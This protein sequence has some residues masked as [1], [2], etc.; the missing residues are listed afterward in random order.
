[1]TLVLLDDGYGG[2]DGVQV[3]PRVP[4]GQANLEHP[5]RD[6]V[7]AHPSILPAAELEPG[8]GRIAAVATELSLPGAGFADVLLVSE[9]GRLILV[10]CKLWRNPQARREVVVQILDYARELAH[11]D[12]EDLQRA[13]S[14]RVGRSGNV[15]YELAREAGSTMTEAAFVDR[16]GRDLRAGRFLL[17]I[18]GDGITE[19]TQR[20]TEYLNVP[21]LAFGFGLIEMAEYR[22]TDPATGAARRIMQPRV[23]ARTATIERHVIRSD[24]PGVVIDAVEQDAAPIRRRSVGGSSNG[25]STGAATGA[26]GEAHVAWRAF[27]AA[28][29]AGMQ[30]DDPG[31]LAPRIGGLNWMRVPLPGPAPLV[32][33]RSTSTQR[34]GAFLKYTG[35]EAF[36]AFEALEADREAIAAEFTDDGLEAPEWVSE[37]DVHTVTVRAP[38]PL[39][40]DGAREDEQRA[41]LARA[42]NRF[43]NSFRPRLLRMA[44]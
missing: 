6:I 24:V 5:L 42:A 36:A 12:Y 31:Q 22:Y 7:F 17:L 16:V 20:L 35:A 19:G 32:L 40:W 38:S 3:V 43:V 10:E 34:V 39:P 9:H 23:I 21:G 4:E 29:T 15:L 28:F 30:F 25:G 18:V 14:D 1:M 44:A 13:I 26:T 11:Y 33:Y 41:W 37:G 8:I 2:G 27:V